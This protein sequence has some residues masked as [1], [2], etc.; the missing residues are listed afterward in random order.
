MLKTQ[1]YTHQQIADELGMTKKSVSN[2]I[3]RYKNVNIVPAENR[4][5]PQLSDFKPREMIKYLYDL[6][7]RIENNEIVYYEKRKVKLEDIIN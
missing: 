6:G 4:L 5:K 2:L 1:G 3:Q 7:F